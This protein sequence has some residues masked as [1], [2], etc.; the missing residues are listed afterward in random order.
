M[1]IRVYVVALCNN[2]TNFHA[3]DMPD[4]RQRGGCYCWYALIT[5]KRRSD[6]FYAWKIFHI[7]TRHSQRRHFLRVPVCPLPSYLRR[8]LSRKCVPGSVVVL[9][10]IY[11]VLVYTLLCSNAS[12]REVGHGRP[13][14][15]RPAPFALVYVCKSHFTLV[16]DGVFL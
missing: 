10:L 1:Y 8:N 2:R 9:R 7:S 14:S 6:V 4:N 15:Q 16:L 3:D 13:C 11:Q 5:C 12:K